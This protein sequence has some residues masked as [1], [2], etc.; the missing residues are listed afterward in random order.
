MFL[1]Y[2]LVKFLSILPLVAV[3]AGLWFL[4]TVGAIFYIRKHEKNN[5]DAT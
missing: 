2:W 3:V 5:K 4:I 1:V